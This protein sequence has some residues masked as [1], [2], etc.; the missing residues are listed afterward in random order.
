[1]YKTFSKIRFIIAIAAGKGGV[2]K[3]S[4]TVNLALALQEAGYAVGVLDA[5]LYGPSLGRM[6]PLDVELKKKPQDGACFFPGEFQGIKVFSLSHIR[7]TESSMSVRAPV[8]NEILL[9]CSRDIIWGELDYL[10]V[11]FPP[12]TG[13]IQL[14]LL[15][16]IPFC[17][18]VLVTTPQ[19]MSV[20]DVKK[21]ANMFHVVGIPI[22]GVIENMTYF[23]EPS[24]F[25]KYYLFGQGGGGRIADL[26]G[27]PFLGE[28]PIEPALCRACD[29]G[30]NFLKEYG[31]L[32]TV[33]IIHDIAKKIRSNLFALESLQGEYLRQFELIWEDKAGGC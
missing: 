10:L 7:P 8:I 29:E 18:A 33:S 27:V 28:I 26:F 19:E 15:Q 4:T 2:G 31:E 9:Q 25:K 1:M 16:N 24:S 32:S 14:T 22:L 5:D 13:D 20:M 11:D 3:S 17:G 23:I 6:M 21:A 30:V 12:G